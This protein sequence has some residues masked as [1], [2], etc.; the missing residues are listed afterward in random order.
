VGR[1]GGNGVGRGGGN[2]VGRGGKWGGCFELMCLIANIHLESSMLT[3]RGVQGQGAATPPLH[4]TASPHLPH[5]SWLCIGTECLPCSTTQYPAH[6]RV[7]DQGSGGWKASEEKSAVY[8]GLYVKV[9]PAM[10]SCSQ[11]AKQPG[12]RTARPADW[13][14]SMRASV[15]SW[16]GMMK[17]QPWSNCE[18]D[19]RRVLVL[20]PANS[21]LIR[22]RS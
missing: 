13:S 14:S 22:V 17:A 5:Q 7:A 2:G 15:A 8:C 16:V 12:A 21:E 18:P 20:P 1:G 10:G 19:V 11:E 4:P 6:W 3:V 9:L